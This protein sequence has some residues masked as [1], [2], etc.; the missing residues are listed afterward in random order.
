MENKCSLLPRAAA[1]TQMGT[2]RTA[3]VRNTHLDVLA[4][5]IRLIHQAKEIKQGMC[6]HMGKIRGGGRGG[7]SLRQHKLLMIGN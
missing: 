1:L 4:L 6:Y 7:A 2:I 3:Y 5:H